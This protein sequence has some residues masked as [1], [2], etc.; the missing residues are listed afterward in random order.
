MPCCRV[1]SFSSHHAWLKALGIPTVDSAGLQ[2]SRHSVPIPGGEPV[3][4]R[5]RLTKNHLRSASQ[6]EGGRNYNGV[7]GPVRGSQ[8]SPLYFREISTDWKRSPS[9]TYFG[10]V[11]P[12]AHSVHFPELR[13]SCPHS[14]LL[15][16]LHYL[17]YF[18]VLPLV[19]EG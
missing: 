14:V 11:S 6:A 4:P 5:A 15:G 18:P 10:T 12:W 13:L 19:S 2:S 1:F 3:E 9:Q 17:G 7:S 8:G 16:G